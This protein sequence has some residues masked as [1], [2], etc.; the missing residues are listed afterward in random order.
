MKC[1]WKLQVESE[2][3]SWDKSLFYYQWLQATLHKTRMGAWL[4]KTERNPERGVVHTAVLGEPGKGKRLKANTF[5]AFTSHQTRP[6]CCSILLQLFQGP[7]WRRCHYAR[8]IRKSERLNGLPSVKQLI[9]GRAGTPAPKRDG[10]WWHDR[11]L[12]DTPEGPPHS[13]TCLV[14]PHRCQWPRVLKDCPSSRTN[15]HSCYLPRQ[16]KAPSQ[17]PGWP[18]TVTSRRPP[19]RTALGWW[20]RPA[21]PALS[22]WCRPAAGPTVPAWATPGGRSSSEHSGHARVFRHYR[23]PLQEEEPAGQTRWGLKYSLHTQMTAA[24]IL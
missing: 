15:S 12:R 7:L 9:K 24:G 21:P 20:A 1:S 19:L 2:V 8:G 17:P 5:R 11:S 6:R 23:G 4:S 22:P 13:G 14:S 18:C 10:F 16:A 3:G